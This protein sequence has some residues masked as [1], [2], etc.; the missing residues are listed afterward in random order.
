LMNKNLKIQGDI[1]DRGRIKWT[2]MM[3]TE[4][5][6]RLRE[7][8]AEDQLT[9]RPELNE[10]DLQSIQE[11]LEVAYKRQ[12]ET[13]IKTWEAGKI[14]SYRGTIKEINIHNKVIF[15]DDP[16]GTD[17]IEVKDIIAMHCVN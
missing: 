16:F 17:R 5:V 9:E 3:L 8:Y 12:C 7:W 15:L 2:A 10:W 14:K 11:E 4:H 1:K 6:E 13:Q